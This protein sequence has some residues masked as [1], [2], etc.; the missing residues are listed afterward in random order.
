M[1]RPPLDFTALLAR[2]D[3]A[4]LLAGLI[5]KNGFFYHV[6]DGKLTPAKVS[7]PLVRLTSSKTATRV[8]SEARKRGIIQTIEE[9]AQSVPAVTK[10][11]TKARPRRVKARELEDD[12][13]AEV[14]E[15]KEPG[16]LRPKKSSRYSLVSRNDFWGVYNCETG[17]VT[18]ISRDQKVA[19]RELKRLQRESKIGYYKFYS[20]IA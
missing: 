19:A 18:I 16:K 3:I 20:G 14:P 17:E 13:E 11:K 12:D 9:P 10:I 6:L 8:L 1:S 4:E 7:A 15:D 5:C 2:P